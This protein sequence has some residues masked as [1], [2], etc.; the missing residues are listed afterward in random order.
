MQSARNE[1]LNPILVHHKAEAVLHDPFFWDKN[2]QGPPFGNKLG[3]YTWTRFHEWRKQHP[4][5]NPLPLLGVV[6]HELKVPNEGWLEMDQDR[7]VRILPF[8]SFEIIKRDDV[9]IALAFSQIIKEG[10]L[11]P[12][13][14]EKAQTALERQTLEVI[15]NHRRWTQPEHQNYRWMRIREV[16]NV[17]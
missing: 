12:A 8:K 9:V 4:L 2:S 3:I 16:L 15:F 5:E 13:I 6:L 11:S 14:K 17:F 10:H 7:L 1:G